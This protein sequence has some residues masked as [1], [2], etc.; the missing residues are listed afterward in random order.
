MSCTVNSE[1][2]PRSRLLCSLDLGLEGCQ[3]AP[4]IPPMATRDKHLFQ[5]LEMPREV[6]EI[7]FKD[8]PK[9]PGLDPEE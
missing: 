3:G 4:Y 6:Q 7:A 8:D 9:Q 2:G 5:R 1:P